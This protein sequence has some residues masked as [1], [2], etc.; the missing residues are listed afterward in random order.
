MIR[1]AR[2][3][4]SRSL[5]AN[6]VA[7]VPPSVQR[8]LPYFRCV[9]S[10]SQCLHIHIRLLPIKYITNTFSDLFLTL[11]NRQTSSELQTQTHTHNDNRRATDA[12]LEMNKSEAGRGIELLRLITTTGIKS[13]TA[14]AL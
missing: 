10:S 3:Y 4:L 9:T 14:K 12:A 2:T 6:A 7:G 8:F 11:S 13:S 5:K 1:F